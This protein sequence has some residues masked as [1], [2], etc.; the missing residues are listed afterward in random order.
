MNQSATTSL[1]TFP[2]NLIPSTHT[3][4]TNVKDT[5]FPATNNFSK[6]TKRANMLCKTK[7]NKDEHKLSLQQNKIYHLFTAR[8]LSHHCL[9]TPNNCTTHSK[10]IQNTF[11][12]LFD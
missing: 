9:T 6:Y 8:K 7:K 2:L 10:H 4:R 3:K 11:K 5:N 12:T 1:N